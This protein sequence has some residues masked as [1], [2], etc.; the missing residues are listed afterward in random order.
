MYYL[1]RASCF[2]EINF[3]KIHKITNRSG[4]ITP[5]AGSSLKSLVLIRHSMPSIS[6]RLFKTS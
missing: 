1:L 6:G 4:S 3:S 5:L 2:N